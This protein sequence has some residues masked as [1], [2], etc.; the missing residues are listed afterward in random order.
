MGEVGGLHNIHIMCY[1]SENKEKTH[2]S[3]GFFSFSRRVMGVLCDYL[4]YIFSIHSCPSPS[5]GVIRYRIL[6]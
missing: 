4:S 6:P 2:Y 3:V 5:I 1:N